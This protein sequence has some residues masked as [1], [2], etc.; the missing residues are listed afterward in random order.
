MANK[1]I[2]KKQEVIIFSHNDRTYEM[3][4]SDDVIKSLELD[5]VKYK[6]ETKVVQYIEVTIGKRVM[7]S[8]LPKWAKADEIEKE[9]VEKYTSK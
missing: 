5:G 7:T 9:L 3:I 8:M 6:K 1:V 2:D 4:A